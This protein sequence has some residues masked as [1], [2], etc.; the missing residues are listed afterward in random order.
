MKTA[1][2]L[3]AG[4]RQKPK[5]ADLRRAVSTAYYAMFHCFAKMCADKMVGATKVLRSNPAWCQ[6]Y[7]SL[8]HGE[9]RS[10]I[11]QNQIMEKFPNAVQDF[12]DTFISLQEK[13]HDAD[14]NPML[15][16]RRSE[17]NIEIASAENAIRDLKTV[18]A[19]DLKA[20][21]V[22]VLLKQK[23]KATR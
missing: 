20:F 10:A 4:K 13:R 5:Q 6:V 12:A 15:R 2:K 16:L 14:Y 11:K 8:G 23:N 9:A 3:A 17:V 1:K 21:A 7:R 22:W 18:P 19:S